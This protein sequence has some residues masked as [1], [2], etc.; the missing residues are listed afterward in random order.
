MTGDDELV[1]RFLAGGVDRDN[2]FHFR[3]L[4]ERRLLVNRCDACGHRHHP[5]RPLCPVCWSFA[6]TPAEVTGRGTIALLTFVT[7]RADD[8]PLGVATVEL[9]EQPGLRYTATLVDPL[10]A[11]GVGI[12]APVELTW[13]DMSAGPSPAFRIAAGR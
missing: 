11:P 2:A 3:G 10:G 4:L 8:A 9:D 5:P 12:G 1:E 6:V 7:R 13:R